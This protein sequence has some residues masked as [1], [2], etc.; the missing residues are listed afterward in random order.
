VT[1]AYVVAFDPSSDREA[2]EAVLS[3][4]VD[5]GGELVLVAGAG[6]VVRVADAVAR[7][8]ET[9]PAVTHVGGVTL[10]DRSPERVRQ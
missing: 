6:V 1:P 2:I 5:A 4:L 10:P 7:D 3:H 8:V 9:H